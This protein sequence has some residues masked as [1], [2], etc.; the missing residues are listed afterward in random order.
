MG[1]ENPWRVL[2]PVCRRLGNRY[3]HKDNKAFGYRHSAGASLAGRGALEEG[4]RSRGRPARLATQCERAHARGVTA[5][6]AARAR[7]QVLKLD[8][9]SALDH[10]MTA[11]SVLP[12]EKAG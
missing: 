3:P 12:L 1:T 10:D 6:S 9:M 5:R 8:V 7:T 2:G 11:V 4:E